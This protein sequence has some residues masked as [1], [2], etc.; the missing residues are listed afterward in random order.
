MQARQEPVLVDEFQVGL[1]RAKITESAQIE[2]P[3]AHDS[4]SEDSDDDARLE[5]PQ[6][7]SQKVVDSI[8]KR[9]HRAGLKIRQ[10][11]HIGRASDDFAHTTTALAGAGSEDPGS[12]YMTD[13]PEPNRPTVKDLIHNPFDTVRA[14]ISEQTDKQSAGQIT[15]KEVPHGDEVNLIHASEA[16]NTAQNDAERLLAIKNLSR[17]MKER[18]ATYARWTFDRHITKIRRLP[19]DEVKLRPRSDF[20]KYDPLEGWIIDWRAYAQSVG[21]PLG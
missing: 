18:Q 21:H 8:K 14:K 2:L 12:R 4:Q 5:N 17:L 7:S 15:A 6:S 1:D 10:T 19:R 11:L 9:K 16:V 3:E 13:A 20:E